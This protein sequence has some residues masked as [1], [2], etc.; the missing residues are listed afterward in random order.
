MY[1]TGEG[2]GMT[3]LIRSRIKEFG[4][5]SQL[6][7]FLAAMYVGVVMPRFFEPVLNRSEL[8]ASCSEWSA[9][10]ELGA[11]S[12]IPICSGLLAGLLAVIL[13][14]LVLT[15]PSRNSFRGVILCAGIAGGA[16]AR[17]AIFTQLLF[18]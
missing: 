1:V 11:M 15:R 18:W 6:P 12:G 14:L 13:L 10:V 16:A 8:L 9:R 7:L 17:V 5:V 4:H 2:G 3:G